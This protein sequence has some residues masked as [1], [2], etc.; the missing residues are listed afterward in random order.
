MY[1]AVS[2]FFRRFDSYGIFLFPKDT[3]DMTLGLII[4]YVRRPSNI[5]VKNL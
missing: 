2:D 4:R 5:Y 1:V 3:S